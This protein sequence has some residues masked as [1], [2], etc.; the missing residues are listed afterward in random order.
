[1][2]LILARVQGNKYY[3]AKVR[4]KG[5][6][7]SQQSISVNAVVPNEDAVVWKIQTTIT[8]AVYLAGLYIDYLEFRLFDIFLAS[9]TYDGFE[10]V[11]QGG[12]P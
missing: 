9:P 3:N 2:Y 11:T 1:M 10:V 4:H 12:V 6:Q 5:I 8:K 7:N